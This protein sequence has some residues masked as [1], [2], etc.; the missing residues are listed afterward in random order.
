MAKG[1]EIRL[2]ILMLLSKNGQKHSS[3]VAKEVGISK[4]SA[5]YHLV[6][7]ASDGLVEKNHISERVIL[8]TITEKGL[9]HL[10]RNIMAEAIDEYARKK[11]QRKTKK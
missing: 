7:L 8:W 1:K 11:A 6:T 9:E 4:D 2:K 5:F 3:V 10:K